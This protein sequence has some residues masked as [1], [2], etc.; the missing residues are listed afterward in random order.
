MPITI[1]AEPL[2]REAFA[3]FGDL[4][5]QS[6]EEP[7][8]I[9]NGTTQRFHR[10]ATTETAGEDAQAIINIFKG[11]P[12]VPPVN[13]TMFERHPLGSQAFVPLSG[14]PFLVVVA[15]NGEQ[16]TPEEFRVFLA[17]PNQGVNYARNVWHHPLIS[18]EEECDFLVVDREGAGTNLEEYFLPQEHQ[19]SAVI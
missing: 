19:F 17:Q 13:I 4:I 14:Q 15:D 16:D 5:D 12:F 7:I 1:K 18:L 9:N 10:L 8:I 11:Q 2:T 6:G 3:T